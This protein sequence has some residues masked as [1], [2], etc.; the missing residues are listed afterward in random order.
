MNISAN[1]NT[2]QAFRGTYQL[3]AN[4]TMPNQDAC[5]LR[6][7]LIGAWS[8]KASNGED[9]IKQLHDFYTKDYEKNKTAPLNIE[10]KLPD[11]DNAN[12]EDSMNKCGQ[13]FN[14]LA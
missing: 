3:N 8:A 13:K 4:Q 1:L 5:L 10:L 7:T 2:S 6:D 9:V 14:K 12:F 11:A